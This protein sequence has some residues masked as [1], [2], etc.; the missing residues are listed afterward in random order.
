MKSIIVR[1]G[2]CEE[3]P[4]S[5]VIAVSDELYQETEEA[6]VGDRRVR[7]CVF[8]PRICEGEMRSDTGSKHARLHRDRVHP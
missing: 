2:A 5:L 1:W 7:T 3:P 4:A 8:N 6:M